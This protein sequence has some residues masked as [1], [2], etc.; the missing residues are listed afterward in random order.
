MTENLRPANHDCS[1]IGGSDPR[2]IDCADSGLPWGC[3]GSVVS[4]EYENSLHFGDNLEVLRKMQ[5]ASVDLIYLDPPFNSNANYNILYGTRRGGPS[6]AQSHAFEDTW[7]WGR[8]AQRALEQT[9]ERHLEAGA[10]LAQVVM[11]HIQRDRR[12]VVVQFL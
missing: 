4:G 12:N 11:R 10:L 9:A 7:T 2:L 5:A 6:Q 1:A 3:G 8:D